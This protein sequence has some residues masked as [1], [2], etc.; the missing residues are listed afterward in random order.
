MATVNARLI[1]MY[2]MHSPIATSRIVAQNISPPR[3]YLQSNS[4]RPS[5]IGTGST[6]NHPGNNIYM[7]S[8]VSIGVAN[9]YTL[10]LRIW[11]RIIGRLVAR[12]LENK[13]LA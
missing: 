7:T 3:A 11:T 8:V 1:K 4:F 6:I 13:G 9:P 12:R 2:I 10:I 5:T